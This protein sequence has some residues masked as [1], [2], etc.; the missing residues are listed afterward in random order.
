MQL[1]NQHSSRVST[2]LDCLHWVREPLLW[3]WKQT[4]L[5]SEL[6][7]RAVD[8]SHSQWRVLLHRN[9]RRISEILWIRRHSIQWD[10][11]PTLFWSHSVCEKTRQNMPLSKRLRRA[12]GLEYLWVDI[13]M[14]TLLG[15]RYW[16]E[17]EWITRKWCCFKY[18]RV[19]KL[20]YVLFWVDFAKRIYFVSFTRKQNV[21]GWESIIFR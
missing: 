4:D 9:R 6:S 10:S 3:F 20:F 5:F 16:V 18:I 7:A 17:L 15:V 13:Q 21:L 12:D 8:L 19:Y 2:E 14:R 11:S 1:L